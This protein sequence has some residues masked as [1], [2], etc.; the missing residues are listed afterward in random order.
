MKG[1][2]LILQNG[3]F[4]RKLCA[5]QHLSSGSDLLQKGFSIFLLLGDLAVNL[6]THILI[7]L[8]LIL[9]FR[10]RDLLFDGSNFALKNRIIPG[11]FRIQLL[12]EF[13]APASKIGGGASDIER[14]VSSSVHVGNIIA[15]LGNHTTVGG[16]F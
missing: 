14:H 8:E 16:A 11:C 13:L 1:F 9:I 3:F 5:R 2:F 7:F 6:S 15:K 10:S 12:I 4:A